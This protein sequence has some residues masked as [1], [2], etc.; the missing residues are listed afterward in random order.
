MKRLFAV[1]AVAASLLVCAPLFA[2]HGFAGRYD[3]DHPVT[4]SG[5]VVEL[6]FMNPH[7]FIIFENKDAAG[8]T[9]R[10]QAELGSAN[11]LAREGWTRA[12]LKAGDHITIIGPQNKNGSADL[13]LSHESKITMTD[14]GKVIHNSI[15]AEQ[16][17]NGQP[18]SGSAA[19]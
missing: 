3:E 12:T 19:N 8:K 10:W 16:G 14:S 2:H 11:L 6:Q 7:S 13:N 17:Q 15:K 9:E 5:T 4:V 18:P 1:T